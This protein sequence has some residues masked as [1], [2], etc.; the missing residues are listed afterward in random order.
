MK[1]GEGSK[2]RGQSNSGTANSTRWSQGKYKAPTASRMLISLCNPST[3]SASKTSF[4]NDFHP[5]LSDMGGEVVNVALLLCNL[6]GHCF[7]GALKNSLNSAPWKLT[8]FICCSG[9]SER[10]WEGGEFPIHKTISWGIVSHPHFFT[11]P[12]CSLCHKSSLPI[13]MIIPQK[14]WTWPI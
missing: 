12:S 13:A 3:W 7:L 11:L 5:E 8:G 2:A 6:W 1:H 9:Q 4:S 10:Q 14:V